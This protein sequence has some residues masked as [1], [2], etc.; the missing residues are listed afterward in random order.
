[1]RMSKRGGVLLYM[2]ERA[3][4]YHRTGQTKQAKK[5]AI[6][7]LGERLPC[8]QE[9]GGSIPPGSTRPNLC[10]LASA[11]CHLN[12]EH[13]HSRRKMAVRFRIATIP[14]FHRVN[15]TKDRSLIL[16][17]VFCLLF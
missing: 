17:L 5:G 13:L 4:A 11:N 3:V 9:V 8:T 6:A 7:Q 15:K 1:M 2:T 12:G 14:N 10:H 16:N